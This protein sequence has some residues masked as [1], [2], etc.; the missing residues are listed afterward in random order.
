[1]DDMISV[2]LMKMDFTK[3]GG[4][5]ALNRDKRPYYVFK[6]WKPHEDYSEYSYLHSIGGQHVKKTTTLRECEM[7]LS[8]IS[9]CSELI[10]IH[11][12]RKCNN[13][14][15]PSWSFVKFE[16][17]GHS[18]CRG[19]GVVQRLIQHKFSLRLG[20]DGTANKS[21]WDHTPGQDARDCAI[22]TRNGRRMFIKNPSHRRNWFRI[23]GKIE[24]LTHD[25][26]F[27][28]IESMIKSAKSKLKR[29]Y[30]IIHDESHSHHGK[31]P[32]G[33]AAF[34]AACF[35]CAVLEFENRVGHKTPCTLP[36]IQEYA[37]G[38]RDKKN[39][40]KC[41]DV[42]N[43][44]I[45]DYARRLR[46]LNLCS[47]KIPDANAETLCFQPQS[48]AKEHARMALFNKCEPLRI[49]LPSKESWGIKVGTSDSGCL[50]I[51]SVSPDGNGWRRGIRNGDY[52]FQVNGDILGIDYTPKKIERLILSMRDPSY[53]KPVVELSLMRKK[54]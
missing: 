17:K 39:N 47:V 11:S 18:T 16:H 34:A 8:K 44:K 49:H 27:G 20:E 38:C 2:G 3:R 31:F 32:H 30:Y 5:F 33:G 50:Y 4:S 53:T 48:A 7:M 1:M 54:K 10:I 9:S 41:R 45:L 52:L 51:E 24:D 43:K 46:R 19:C 35:Y 12:T 14:G 13:C 26:H 6:N 21:Q 28:A 42:T 15:R 36:R 29:Y 23:A 37:Q 22:T 40:R 25:W